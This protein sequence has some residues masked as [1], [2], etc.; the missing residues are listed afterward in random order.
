MSDPEEP[1]TGV[2][3]RPWSL[4]FENSDLLAKSEDFQGDISA[5]TEE[6]ANG[7]NER[8]DEIEDKRTVVTPGHSGRASVIGDRNPLISGHDVLLTTH[9]H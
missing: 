8:K 1:I 5:G 4:P 6:G 3:R 9:R 2:Q 7:G